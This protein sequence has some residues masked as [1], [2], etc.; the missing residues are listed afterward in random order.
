[1]P[2]AIVPIGFPAEDPEPPA[3]IRKEDAVVTIS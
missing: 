3:R 1:M 2:V